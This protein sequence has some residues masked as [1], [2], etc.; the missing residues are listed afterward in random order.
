MDEECAVFILV[1]GKIVKVS[2]S[3]SKSNANIT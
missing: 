1:K 3:E 2:I